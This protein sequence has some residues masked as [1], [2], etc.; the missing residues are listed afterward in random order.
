MSETPP[1]MVVAAKGPL[2]LERYAAL[3]ALID[4]FGGRDE[5]LARAG[6]VC[7]EWTEQQ[8]A[9]L[10]RMA[11]EA[12][13]MRFDLQDRYNALFLELRATLEQGESVDEI[14]FEAEEAE[15]AVEPVEPVEPQPAGDNGRA[16]PSQERPAP[17]MPVVVAP[18]SPPMASTPGSPAVSAG[19]SPWAAAAAQTPEAK[20]GPPRRARHSTM[21]PFRAVASA[22]GGA[23]QRAPRARR[24]RNDGALPFAPPPLASAG[25]PSSPAAPAALAAAAR[26]ALPFSAPAAA[27]ARRSAASLAG[28]PFA[29]AGP[30][31]AS[32]E[33]EQTVDD[34]GPPSSSPSL[35]S[36][37]DEQQQ[38]AVAPALP[39]ARAEGT[40]RSSSPPR[41]N[42][43][44]LPF[45]A[46]QKDE[47]DEMFE[48]FEDDD[49]MVAPAAA[50]PFVPAAKK[51]PSS[52][53]A[54][55]ADKSA[56]PFVPAANKDPSAPVASGSDKSAL[57]FAPVANMNISLPAAG[58][59]VGAPRLTL[60]QFASITAEIANGPTG[61]TDV[62]QRYGFDSDG[63]V[64]EKQAWAKR[65]DASPTESERY[66]Q[67][68][69]EYREW[70]Q[71][72]G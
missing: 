9:W 36:T 16:L 47:Y 45:Q 63:Y 50:L 29:P 60:E 54:S 35:S 5:V 61:A 48:T 71:Q 28:L 40:K 65:F 44:A 19:P 38:P 4:T 67:L 13:H 34:G 14:A 12:R 64:R 10:H 6:M 20:G 43:G 69:R 21:L 51:H 23:G 30:A 7:E 27:P 46:A 17:E 52:R 58:G 39:F 37:L 11:K 55:S 33:D 22:A 32:I 59:E 42:D 25:R 57:P 8:Q 26:Q 3:S 66:A 31:G 15:E 2:S 53:A 62:E 24:T 1:D 56:L 68:V 70:L 18:R 49:E 72:G 41:Q